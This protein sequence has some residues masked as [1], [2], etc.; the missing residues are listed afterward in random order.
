[1]DTEGT[2]TTATYPQA[3]TEEVLDGLN[4]LLRL[5]HD[6]IGAYDV[7]IERLDDRDFTSQIAGFKRD[8]EGHIEALNQL[9]TELGGAPENKPHVTGILKKAMQA[10]GSIGGDKGLLIAWRANEYQVR[11]KYDAYASKA[12]HWP[13]NVK[14]LIDANALDEERHYHWVADVLDRLGVGP[15]EGL[16]TDLATRLR[17]TGARMGLSSDNI[18]ARAREAGE[19]A[20]THVADGLDTAANRLDRMGEPDADGAQAR[21]AGMA[22]RVADGMH[23]AADR[24]RSGEGIDLRTEIEG[25]V[26]ERP[27][28]TLLT[29]FGVGFVLGRLLR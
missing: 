1:V 2:R 17:E 23:S 26:R 14:R 20:R 11:S 15:S 13:D 5:D 19:T 28:R 6:A 3:T 16:D 9:I 8:H 22:H 10:A 7:A 12:M 29:V 18:S 4:D 25:Q 24:V 27:V 21:M